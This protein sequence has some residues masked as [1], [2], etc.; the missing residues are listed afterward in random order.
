MD[1]CIVRALSRRWLLNE[2]SFKLFYS[3]CCTGSPS[4][5][6]CRLLKTNTESLISLWGFHCGLFWKQERL[7]SK[8]A[9][10]K[11]CG[12]AVCSHVC[13]EGMQGG[14]VCCFLMLSWLSMVWVMPCAQ[15][16][17]LLT[18]EGSWWA[19]SLLWHGLLSQDTPS[20]DTTNNKCYGKVNLPSVL[21]TSCNLLGQ[22]CRVN[23]VTIHF[24]SSLPYFSLFS[25]SLTEDGVC[26]EPSFTDEDKFRVW[27]WYGWFEIVWGRAVQSES[28]ELSHL[29][30][31]LRQ[32]R[33][34]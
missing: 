4:L 10:S 30:A 32:C 31:E 28:S 33:G 34:S 1:P 15:T 2:C 6:Y 19:R 5:S 16:K 25:W 24:F 18:P 17:L 11:M 23:P 9:H 3:L 22:N 20:E 12:K 14:W 7:F 27:V 26:R 13:K 29:G 21:E 8:Y